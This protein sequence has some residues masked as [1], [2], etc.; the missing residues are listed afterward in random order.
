[1]FMR[2]SL[3]LVLL[4]ALFASTRVGRSAD[5]PDEAKRAIIALEQDVIG[6]QAKA[7]LDIKEVE[8][9]AAVELLARVEQCIDSLQQI[10]DSLTKAGKLDEAVAIRERIKKLRNGAIGVLPAPADMSVYRGQVGKVLHFEVV[11][12][13][14]ANVYGTDIYSDDSP[15]TTAAVHAGVIKAGEKGVVKVTIM[16]GQ[17]SFRGTTRNGVTSIG[18]P[19]YP[20]AYKVEAA[21]RIGVP[22]VPTDPK[23]P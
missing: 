7:E 9:R 17:A 19:A 23:K 8:K 5:L 21:S 12:S 14:D 22:R 16:P 15:L 2:R 11:G 4:A 10:Q 6:I 3:S 18:W 13:A 1:M 20:G